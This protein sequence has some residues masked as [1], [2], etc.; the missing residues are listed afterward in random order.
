MKTIPQNRSQAN[1][2]PGMAPQGIPAVYS[3]LR[4]IRHATKRFT[5]WAYCH[6]YLSMDTT[7]RIFGWLDLRDA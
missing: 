7:Q 2:A 5:M 6:E 3:A 1:S 4:F